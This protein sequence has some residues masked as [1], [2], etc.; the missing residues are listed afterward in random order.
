MKRE[1][2]AEF[3]AR[4]GK[5]QKIPLME[6]SSKAEVVKAQTGGPA[7]FLTL[8]EADLFYGEYKPK[9]ASKK[10]KVSTID[11]SAL[12]EELRKKYV[13]GVLKN[14]QEDNEEDF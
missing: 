10:S 12:P 5:I 4:G 14:D 6:S 11:I 7:V 8:E 1:T 2:V 3:V 13:D 9:K